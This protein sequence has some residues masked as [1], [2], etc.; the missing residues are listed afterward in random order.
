MTFQ[1]IGSEILKR[2]KYFRNQLILISRECFW[3]LSLSRNLDER[4]RESNSILSM[5]ARMVFTTKK[6][7]NTNTMPTKP[8]LAAHSHSQYF[9]TYTWTLTLNWEVLGTGK[10]SRKKGSHWEVRASFLAGSIKL[11]LNLQLIE[12]TKWIAW[13]PTYSRL[14]RFPTSWGTPKKLSSSSTLCLPRIKFL[15]RKFQIT[16]WN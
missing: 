3:H 11:T 6:Q 7:L 4:F 16:K 12:F 8:L 1:L 14:N 9:N 15:Q 10:F 13:E 2:P 5:R